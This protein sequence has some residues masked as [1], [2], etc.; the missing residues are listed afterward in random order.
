MS[1]G[2]QR[3]RTLD[4]RTQAIEQVYRKRYSAFRSALAAV[5]G[6][7]EATHDVVQEAFAQAIHRR[8]S[9]RG[10]G[11]LE[12][13]IWKIA[14]RCALET[15]SRRSEAVNIDEVVAPPAVAGPESDPVLAAALRN[16]PPRRRL[17][18]F[19]RYFADLPY[20]EIADICEMSEGTVAATLSQARAAL[21]KEMTGATR[22]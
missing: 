17:V 6:D 9:Y 15:R 4:R 18:V 7:S 8:R 11:P 19:L 16:L 22:E 3:A 13:W 12:S 2:S 1:L 21:R 14:L 20:A 10:D 5:V